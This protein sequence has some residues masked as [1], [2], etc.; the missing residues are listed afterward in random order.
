MSRLVDWVK[1]QVVSVLESVRN[2]VQSRT[3]I[4][5]AAGLVV[6]VLVN[7]KLLPDTL[8]TQGAEAIAYI[9]C[10]VFRVTAT[11]DLRTGS[12]LK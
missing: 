2:I 11:T 7:K 1:V 9:L 4:A 8:V 10:A 3:V 6:H 12:P 5:A